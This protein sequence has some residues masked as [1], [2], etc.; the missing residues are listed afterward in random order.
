[1]AGVLRGSFGVLGE[2][3]F[4]LFFTGYATSMIGSAMVPVALTFAL[5]DRGY[6]ATQVGWTLSAQSVPLV[7]LLLAGGAVADRRS[8][9]TVMLMADVARACSEL[10]LG[11][12]VVTGKPS[13]WEFMV[14]AG[15]IGAGLAFFSPAMTGFVPA[16]ASPERLQQANGMTSLAFSASQLVGPAI[17][18]VLV[19]TVGP[20]WAIVADGLSYVVSA[21][22]LSRLGLSEQLPQGHDG[23]AQHEGLLGQLRQ[24]WV[25][26]RSRTWLWVVVGQFSLFHLLVLPP[27]VVLGAL[28]AKND[29]G[30]AGAWAAVLAAQGAGSIVGGLALLHV[31]PAR[32]ILAGVVGTLGF[33]L[34]LALLA[35]DVPLPLLV[36]GAFVAGGGSAFFGVLWDTTLQRSVPPAV[37][38]RVSS[39]D[40][41]GSVGLVPLGYALAGPM[42][43]ALGLHNALGLAAGLWVLLTVAAVSVPAVRAR[44]SDLYALPASPLPAG[45]LPASP[46]PAGPLPAGPLPAGP[47]GGA[48]VPVSSAPHGGTAPPSA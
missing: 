14:L 41:L 26:F 4:R 36:A 23:P 42:G 25:E 45:P 2:R 22:C 30:G 15:F 3:R 35:L 11:L 24:G 32:P 9:R 40:W 13:L 7:A 16:V 47:A 20:G 21:T 29:L 5:L 33:A 44:S 17:A 39:Y 37:L 31:R 1:M 8:R 6:S 27:F 34:P 12:L 43:A 19:T 38:S 10:T 48:L 18:G 28:L 46:L